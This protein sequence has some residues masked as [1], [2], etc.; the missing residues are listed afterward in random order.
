MRC[1]FLP[2]CDRLKKDSIPRLFG[3]TRALSWI[4]PLLLF[5]FPLSS[6]FAA[7]L[8]ATRQAIEARGAGW[9]AAETS[10]SRMDIEERRKRLGLV[11]PSLPVRMEILPASQAPSLSLASALDWR[12]NGGNFVT[13]V[14]NQGSCG[15]CWAFATAGALESATMIA[16]HTPGID[17]NLSEQV[18]LSCGA[19]GS[20]AGGYIDDAGDLPVTGCWDGTGA[21]KIGVFRKGQW[22]LD[23]N[24]NRSWDGCGTDACIASFGVAG[25]IPVVGEW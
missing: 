5:F 16:S 7:E 19:S 4:F 17:L 13:P 14:R 12:N 11:R 18:L 6:A 9:V 20:C 2:W 8:S 22:F 23:L 24:G 3:G 1:S 25:D 15:S 10:I 21:A